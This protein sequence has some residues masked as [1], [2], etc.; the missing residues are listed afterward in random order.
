MAN[1]AAQLGAGLAMGQQMM[2]AMG[3]PQTT[4]AA[5]TPPPLP[6][7]SSLPQLLSTAEVATTLGVSEQDVLAS[8]NDGS[9][10]GKKIGATWR[11]SKAA[12]DEFLKS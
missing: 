5:G 1:T 11:I 2:G 6:A 8:L 12:L 7:G 9:L 4:P 3:T 10:K